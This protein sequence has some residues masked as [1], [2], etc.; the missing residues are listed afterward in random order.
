MSTLVAGNES[1]GP[2]RVNKKKRARRREQAICLHSTL[3][4]P[5]KN[6]SVEMLTDSFCQLKQ[7]PEGTLQQA[8]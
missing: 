7:H 2:T 4:V 5:T 1:L 3:L 6:R 8:T